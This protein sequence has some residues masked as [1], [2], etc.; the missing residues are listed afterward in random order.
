MR[1]RAALRLTGPSAV[2][3]MS[4]SMRT[5]IPRYSSG[6]ARSSFLKYRPG[7]IVNTMPS[8]RMPSR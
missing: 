1:G 7:S 2:I 5:P 8:V 4:S 6:M 3:R